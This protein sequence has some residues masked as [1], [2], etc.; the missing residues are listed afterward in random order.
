MIPYIDKITVRLFAKIFYPT[1][2]LQ[3]KGAKKKFAKR[4]AERKFS[5]SAEGEEGYAPSTAQAFE[6]A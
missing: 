1:F 5:P 4:N 3:E 6:K 2:S